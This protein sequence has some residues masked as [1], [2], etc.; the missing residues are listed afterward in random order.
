VSDHHFT[1]NPFYVDRSQPSRLSDRIYLGGSWTARAHELLR[2]LGVT[3]VVN[4][5]PDD[6]GCAAAG[7]KVHHAPIDDATAL[8]PGV[9]G[10]FLLRMDAWEQSGDVVLIHCHAGI[11]RTSTFAIAWLM[12]KAGCHQGTDLA[13]AWRVAE[14]VVAR[15]RDIIMP[16]Y[17]LKRGVLAFFAG[18]LPPD[19]AT[20]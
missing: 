19:G 5:T 20:P 16:H 7:F 6:F 10:A 8:A 13:A 3:A 18:L 2:E 14:D 15:A 9:I 12:Y 11:S 17:L 1:V 4:L